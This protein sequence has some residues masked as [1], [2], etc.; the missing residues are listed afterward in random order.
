[1]TPGSSTPGKNGFGIS[2]PTMR[3]SQGGMMRSAPSSQPM[4]QSGCDAGAHVGRAERAVDPDR[5]DLREP[6][7]QE[8]DGGG[9]E[10]QRRCAL[11]V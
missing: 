8:H 4:Y 5:V 2:N 11:A 1:M 10:Q 9:E 3:I 6:A 7:E